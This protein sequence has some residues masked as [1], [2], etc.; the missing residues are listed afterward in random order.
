MPRHSNLFYNFTLLDKTVEHLKQNSVLWEERKARYKY[1]NDYCNENYLYNSESDTLHE[2]KCNC[3]NCERCRPIKKYDLLK[4]IVNV[5]EKHNLRRH[6]VITL[7]GYT[8]RS[9]FCN[10][11][12]SFDY[13]MRKFNEFRVY[14]KRKFGKN[15]SYICLIR[16]QTDGFCHLHI[17]VGDYIPKEWLDDVLKRIN[18][19][20]PFITYVDIKRLGNYLSKYWYKEHEWFIPKNKKHYTHSADIEL[21]GILPSFGWY[22]FMMPKGP[23]TLGCDKVDYIYRCMDFINPYHNPPPFDLM[24]SGFYQDV[25]REFGNNYVGFLRKHG[26]RNPGG[27]KKNKNLFYAIIRQTKLFYNGRSHHV[28]IKEFK[29]PK[30]NKQKK[31]RTGIFYDRKAKNEFKHLCHMVHWQDANQTEPKEKCN[32]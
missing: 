26:V 31:F 6:L 13:A 10:A 19:G 17:L 24:L 23:Y 4:N 27:F 14:Y 9:L 2:A 18:L 1:A 7:P 25:H 3:Y 15:L 5:A 28:N 21:E 29:P 20:F 32:K 16:S 12:E 8:F 30:Y 11:D 22:F